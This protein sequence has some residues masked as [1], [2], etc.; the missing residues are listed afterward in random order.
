MLFY[1]IAE[2]RINLFTDA[3]TL[4]DIVIVR[5]SGRI[6]IR[7]PRI[8]E[9][10]KALQVQLGSRIHGCEWYFRYPL[11]WIV[12]TRVENSSLSLPFSLS[13]RERDSHSR[14]IY[15][16]YP[17]SLSVISRLWRYYNRCDTTV[18]HAGSTVI[19]PMC[20]VLENR[21]RWSGLTVICN[22]VS[23]LFIETA[24]TGRNL[25]IFHAPK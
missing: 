22:R 5:N 1:T 15:I 8:V 6:E 2:T 3:F 21:Q 17:T 11:C 7:K 10:S 20:K 9:S 4:R 23:P 12:Q 25:I 18:D 24:N 13:T 14:D 19:V 16:H